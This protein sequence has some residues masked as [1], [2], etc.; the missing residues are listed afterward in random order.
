M[1]SKQQ[2]ENLME[3]AG[4]Y[5]QS[6]FKVK[7]ATFATAAAV[8]FEVGSLVDLVGVLSLPGSNSHDVAEHLGRSIEHGVL[9]T[10]ATNDWDGIKQLV[11]QL[12]ERQ[13]ATHA[14]IVAL[15]GDAT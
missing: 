14:R 4:D 8:L 12:L 15:A 1:D 5:L 7:G 2:I 9:L 6:A 11:A 10:V 13:R 3:D